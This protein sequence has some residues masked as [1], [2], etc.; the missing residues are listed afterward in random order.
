MNKQDVG[1]IEFIDDKGSFR[2]SGAENTSYLYF[3]VAG[4][5]GLKSCVTPNLGGQNKS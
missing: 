2:I 4:E 5:K 3:P 1:K